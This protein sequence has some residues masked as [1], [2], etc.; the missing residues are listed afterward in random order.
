MGAGLGFFSGQIG[1]RLQQGKLARQ[2]GQYERHSP[3]YEQPT[4]LR[5]ILSFDASWP[6]R[7]IAVEVL[8]H[9]SWQP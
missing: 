9:I 4:H 2:P 5:S 3:R 6:L 7:Q 1:V 8:S